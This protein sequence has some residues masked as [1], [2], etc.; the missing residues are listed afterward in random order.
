MWFRATAGL[1]PAMP[2]EPSRWR[3]NRNSRSRTRAPVHQRSPKGQQ[4][5]LWSMF[6]STSDEQPY[7]DEMDG[8][9]A[10]SV[11]P[12]TEVGNFYSSF[13]SLFCIEFRGSLNAPSLPTI[14]IHVTTPNLSWS[15]VR[16]TWYFALKVY[17]LYIYVQYESNCKIMQKFSFTLWPRSG[18]ADVRVRS[19]DKH[20]REQR[21][22]CACLVVTGQWSNINTLYW[23]IRQAVPQRST[24]DGC[25]REGVQ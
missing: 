15:G 19:K 1:L 12:L 6:A 18:D 10:S 16:A 11:Y 2:F 3:M 24:N 23:L 4:G 14:I 13:F 21:Y 20:R 7:E 9:R 22:W 8:E 17:V 25:Q 5:S